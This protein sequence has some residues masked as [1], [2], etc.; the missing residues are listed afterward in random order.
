MIPFHRVLIATAIAFCAGFAVWSV[1]SYRQDPSVGTLVVGI[2]FG[3]AALA[4]VYYLR[5]LNRFLG[6]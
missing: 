6:R 1:W 5:H 2:I 4:L 3:A